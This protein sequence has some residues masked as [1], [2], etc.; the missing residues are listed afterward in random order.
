MDITNTGKE[1]ANLL[2][3]PCS[4]QKKK[5][6]N[7]PAIELYDGPFYRIVKKHNLSNI[8]ILIVSANMV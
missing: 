7:V 1:K 8:I 5:L 2:V 6:N 4:K 3:L